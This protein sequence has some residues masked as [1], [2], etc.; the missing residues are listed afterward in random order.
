MKKLISQ[1][2]NEWLELESETGLANIDLYLGNCD[3]KI[4]ASDRR[5]LITEW[6]GT[7]ADKLNHSNY[8]NF[9][10]NC[11]EKTGMLMTA[12]GSND[13]KIVP[14]GLPNYKVIPPIPIP[15]PD[16]HPDINPPEPAPEPLDEIL[17][18]ELFPSLTDEESFDL[19]F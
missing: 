16:E 8:D 15:G 11:F 3:R 7:A 14:E 12:D 10:W 13:A 4:T 18:D 19:D 17:E 2:Q 6:V 9:R 5:I 1:A